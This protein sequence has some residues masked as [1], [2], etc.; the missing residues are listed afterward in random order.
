MSDQDHGPALADIALALV[1]NLGHQRACRIDH[2]QAA[3]GGLALD[4]LRHAMRAED[5]HRPV[6]NF[7]DVLDEARAFGLQGFDHVFVM[8]DLMPH[9]DRR[10]VFLQR[11]LDDVDRPHDAGAEAARLGQHHI[12]GTQLVPG[13][14]VGLTQVAP[15]PA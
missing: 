7:G 8:D 2:R 3:V 10:A 9:I 14:I 5:R 13:S 11:A 1:M 12:E 4:V 6:G 15:C